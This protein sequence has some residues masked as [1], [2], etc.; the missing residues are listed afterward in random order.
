MHTQDFEIE[1]YFSGFPSHCDSVSSGQSGIGS[2]TFST[3][4]AVATLYVKTYSLWVWFCLLFLLNFNLL[5]PGDVLI[6]L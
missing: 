2:Q 6:G 5:T 1:G 4:T 3:L